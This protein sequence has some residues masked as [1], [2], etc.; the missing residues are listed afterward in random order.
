[1]GFPKGRLNNRSLMEVLVNLGGRDLV[2]QEC[3]IGTR[4]RSFQVLVVDV[5]GNSL[6]SQS[7]GGGG[8]TFTE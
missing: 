8:A 7:R 6:A 3:R 2:R 5:G 1:M 4:H